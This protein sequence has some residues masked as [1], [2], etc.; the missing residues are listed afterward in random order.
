MSATKS[1]GLLGRGLMISERI[2]ELS[3]CDCEVRDV[4]VTLFKTH[5]QTQPRPNQLQ[6]SQVCPGKE[7]FSWL[8][9]KLLALALPRF[10]PSTFYQ[11][12]GSLY[13]PPSAPQ[14]RPAVPGY[15]RPESRCRLSSL[16]DNGHPIE[17]R[18]G[19]MSQCHT[20]DWQDPGAV[21]VIDPAVRPCH[22]EYGP[23]DHDG[24]V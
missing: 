4:W 23:S 5:A 16:L 10:S 7:Y 15:L 19:T 12:R 9:K 13:L 11:S 21:L 14:L 1:V 6:A 2:T 8:G 24:A 22:M 17:E 3:L 18:H 20:A